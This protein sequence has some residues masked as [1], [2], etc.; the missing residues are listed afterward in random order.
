MIVGRARAGGR[1][2][3]HGQLLLNDEVGGPGAQTGV[4]EVECKISHR[5][6][7]SGPVK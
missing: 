4:A 2:V 3:V 5:T 6:Q 1:L 7:I